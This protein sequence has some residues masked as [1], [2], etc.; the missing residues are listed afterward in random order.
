MAENTNIEWADATLNFWMG[1]TRCS[2]GCR[3]CYAETMLQSRYKLKL[4]GP[5]APRR[6]VAST[7]ATLRKIQKRVGAGDISKNSTKGLMVFVNDFADV[8]EDYDGPLVVGKGMEPLFTD[9][10]CQLFTQSVLSSRCRPGTAAT[11][12]DVRPHIWEVIEQNPSIIFQL[13][14]KRPENI[15]HMVPDSWKNGFPANVWIGTSVEDQQSAEK[16]IPLLLQVPAPVRFL[17]CE[18]LIGQVDFTVTDDELGAQWNLLKMGIHWVICGGESGRNARPMNPDWARLLRDQCVSAGV[19][20]FF[21]QWGEWR[22]PFPEEDFNTAFGRAGKPPAFLVGPDG[23]VH[24]YYPL[25]SQDDG[26]NP[27]T[28]QYKPMLRIGKKAAGRML[29]GKEWSEFPILKVDSNG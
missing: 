7:D 11:I 25:D 1:C 21:K 17:S 4:W 13:L 14:T 23:L 27:E 6:L 22:P 20:F 10:E 15:M 5:K 2:E 16:R 19:P 24:C 28:S 26:W 12:A 9:E 18:P 29:D 8:F 3:N